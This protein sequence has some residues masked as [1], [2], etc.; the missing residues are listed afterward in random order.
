MQCAGSRKR[1]PGMWSRLSAVTINRAELRD[2]RPMQRPRA[3]FI[4]AGWCWTIGRKDRVGR[5]FRTL[6][7][8]QARC[9]P[10]CS[11]VRFSRRAGP[12]D[13]RKRGVSAVSRR[14]NRPQPAV[15]RIA[16]E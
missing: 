12:N 8:S 11:F 4:V 3:L 14:L 2:G 9:I 15:E 6:A 13:V 5:R 16:A 10:F 7:P 1:R